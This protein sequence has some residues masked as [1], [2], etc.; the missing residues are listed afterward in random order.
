MCS[1]IFE[2]N[3]MP[4]Q[5]SIPDRSVQP[6]VKPRVSADP[7]VPAQ[8]GAPIPGL[9]TAL[10]AGVGTRVAKGD[11]LLTHEAMKMQPKR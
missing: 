9:I 10:T 3:G 2:L 4:R 8:I 7:A 11:K 1:L 6:K 5:L